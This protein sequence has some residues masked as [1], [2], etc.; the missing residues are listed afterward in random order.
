VPD[1]PIRG[2]PL[3]D[4]TDAAD[5]EASVNPALNDL[6]DTPRLKRGSRAG[7]PAFGEGR[8]FYESTDVGA[9]GLS[10]D[11]GNAW[12]EVPRYRSGAIGTRPAATEG[13]AGWTWAD[14]DGV[15]WRS[16]GTA[17]VYAGGK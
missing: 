14:A 2:Y 15:H 5:L 3:V 4:N 10:Y 11:V 8:T 13:N 12:I 7:R 6:D 17:W 9:Q 16:T 1:S